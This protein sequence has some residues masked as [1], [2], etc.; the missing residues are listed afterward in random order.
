MFMEKS[1]DQSNA[2]LPIIGFYFITCIIIIGFDG[3]GERALT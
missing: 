2:W 3:G 1:F